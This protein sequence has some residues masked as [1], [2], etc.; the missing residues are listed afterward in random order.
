LIGADLPLLPLF[1]PPHLAIAHS[2][3]SL[4]TPI[5]IVPNP[6]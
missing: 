2:L 6:F 4:S 1:L 3:R 5:L